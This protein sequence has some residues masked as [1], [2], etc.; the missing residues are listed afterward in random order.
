MIQEGEVS[1]PFT[2]CLFH[3]LIVGLLVGCQTL[4]AGQNASTAQSP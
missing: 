2:Q 1:Q 4:S 3:G